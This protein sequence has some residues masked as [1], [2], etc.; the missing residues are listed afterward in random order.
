M[1]EN[2]YIESRK[3]PSVWLL[4]VITLACFIVASVL[5]FIIQTK[6]ATVATTR[7]GSVVQDV[8][9]FIAPAL[10]FAALGGRKPM[11]VLRLNVAPPLGLLALSVFILFM[12]MPMFESIVIWNEN[13]SFPDALAPLEQTMR[14][15]ENSAQEATK[16]IM[17]EHTVPSL[18]LSLVIVSLLAGFSEEIWFRGAFQQSF[19]RKH[20]HWAIWITAFIFSAIHCQF[21][22]FFPRLLLGA[23]LGYTFYWTGSLWVPII[24]H[25]L[26]NAMVVIM[27]YTGNNGNLFAPSEHE[28]PKTA[29][30]IASTFAVILL[31]RL[32]ARHK[33]VS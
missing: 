19:L 27:E 2:I 10:A 22:G 32:F 12:G 26:N 23:F 14:N 9:L 17:G 3:S 31:L 11:S 15:M 30:I 20:P 33:K 29:L 1:K 6:G 4:L 28:Y 16:L 13:I 7:L 24:V 5:M 25:A 8:L 21:F 18:I